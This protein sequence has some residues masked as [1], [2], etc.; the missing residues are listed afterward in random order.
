VLSILKQKKLNEAGYIESL[1]SKMGK[2]IDKIEP[3]IFTSNL[4][5]IANKYDLLEYQESE[6][7]KW[8]GKI[9][10]SLCHTHCAG[11]FYISCEGQRYTNMCQSLIE[12]LLLNPTIFY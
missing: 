10:R 4:Q 6:N 5:I 7:R 9:L 3:S 8:M 11:L 2:N 12:S 1:R